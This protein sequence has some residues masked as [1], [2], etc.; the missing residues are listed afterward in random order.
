MRLLR[1][2]TFGALGISLVLAGVLGVSILS[3]RDSPAH[4]GSSNTEITM[5]HSNTSPNYTPAV[6]LTTGGDQSGPSPCSAGE[7]DATTDCLYI[8]AKHIDNTTGAS[9]FQIDIT[10]DARIIHV[11]NLAYV[12]SWLAST[13]RSVACL[14]PTVTEDLTTGAGHAIV[15]CNTLLA[16]PPYG[17]N[18]PSHCDGLIGILAYESQST[19]TGSTV[20]NFSQSKLVDTPPNP[21]NEAAIPATVRSVGVTV[22]PCADYNGDNTVRIGDIL[23]VVSKYFTGDYPADLSGD[24]TVRVNDIL[25]AV[26]EYFASCVAHW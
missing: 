17:P 15:S 21:D 6:V 5:G 7:A 24:G 18:C 23:Y 26:G 4:A 3:G 22:A 14:P 9:A 8:W 13:G 25:L 12:N 16:P 10:Y 2:V 1:R 19:G 20:L 11:D